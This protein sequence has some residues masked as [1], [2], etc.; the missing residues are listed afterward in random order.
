MDKR[1]RTPALPTVLV[2]AMMSAVEQDRSREA[3]GHGRLRGLCA[4]VV[5]GGGEMP[6]ARRGCD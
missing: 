3:R 2:Q 5:C 1:H 6:L 4:V